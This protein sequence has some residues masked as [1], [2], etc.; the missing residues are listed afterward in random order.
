MRFQQ[1]VDKTTAAVAD[2]KEAR[3]ALMMGRP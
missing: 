1:L 2:L 3:R